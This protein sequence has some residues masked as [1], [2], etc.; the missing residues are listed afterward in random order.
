MP[1]SCDQRAHG[2]PRPE[3]PPPKGHPRRLGR[4]YATDIPEH[5]AGRRGSPCEKPM[6]GDS[7]G[8]SGSLSFS[9][10]ISSSMESIHIR[11]RLRPSRYAFVV[12]EGDLAASLQAASV[13]AA[14]WGGIYNP[15]I[16]LTPADRR[17][18][19]LKAFDPDRLVNL[20]GASLPSDLVGRF[21]S[22]IMTSFATARDALSISEQS[23]TY[24]LKTA[25]SDRA[26]PLRAG[27]AS[28]RLG[29]T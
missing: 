27:L 15:I 1:R 20:T 9:P 19:L 4:C 11:Q 21:K 24:S 10:G 28:R 22:R 26:S 3:T 16:P 6:C 23:S 7:V 14:L 12:K 29:T 18:G 5:Q 17:D 8:E 13:N 2:R 25:S